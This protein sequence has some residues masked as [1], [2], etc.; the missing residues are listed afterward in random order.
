LKKE[1]CSGENYPNRHPKTIVGKINFNKMNRILKLGVLLLVV[2]IGFSSCNQSDEIVESSSQT[3]ANDLFLKLGIHK[4]T[5]DEVVN[6]SKIMGLKSNITAKSSYN[7]SE[8]DDVF[9]YE[10]GDKAYIF[11][12]KSNPNQEFVI[13]V[14]SKNEVLA[15]KNILLSNVSSLSNFTTTY[16]DENNNIVTINIVNGV[17]QEGIPVNALG[18]RKPGETFDKCFVRTWTEFAQDAVGILSSI[19]WPLEIA[20]AV[21]ISCSY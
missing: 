1:Y 18:R 20:A 17:A 21:A 10:S 13:K 5:K 8:A 19:V 9:Y 3:K 6:L 2:L 16:N 12:S 15:E 7:L 11:K 4:R 14:N